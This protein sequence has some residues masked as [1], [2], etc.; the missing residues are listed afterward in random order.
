MDDKI[1]R[2]EVMEN[3]DKTVKLQ[4]MD[5]DDDKLIR[6]QVMGIGGDIPA[7][8]EPLSVTE[9]GT[10]RTPEGVDGYDP[11][12]VNV[13]SVPPA[14]SSLSVTENGTYIVPEGVDGYNPVIVNVESMPVDSLISEFDFLSDT[15]DYDKVRNLTNTGGFGGLIN[16]SEGKMVGPTNTQHWKSTTYFNYGKMYR[17]E[18]EIGEI[19][20]TS[21]ASNTERLRGII[22]LG[23]NASYGTT[24][25]TWDNNESKW[26]ITNSGDNR[27]LDPTIYDGY[28]YFNNKKIIIYYGCDMVNGVLVR[29]ANYYNMY[30]DGVKL[31]RKI[32]IGGTNNDLPLIRL[33]SIGSYPIYSMLGARFKSVKIWE[34]YGPYTPLT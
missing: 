29:D 13:P 20:E 25:L 27:F 21:Y 17:A 22:Y 23:N 6:H 10:Y 19:D 9:N 26:R 2:S 28:T 18:I 15:P 31:A 16:T 32:Q 33:G 8:I 12:S 14:I 1:I 4:V 24:E 30:C 11:V 3:D 5:K 34:Y 7:V